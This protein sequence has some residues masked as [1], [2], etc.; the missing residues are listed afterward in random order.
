MGPIKVSVLTSVLNQ[1]EWLKE[2]IASVIASTFKDWEQ[3][4][5]DDG[6]TEDIKGIVESFNDPRVRYFRFP[7]N[8]GI[9]HGSNF[10]LSICAGEY[11]CLLAADEVVW[12]EKMQLQYDYLEANSKVDCVWGLPTR[13]GADHRVFQSEFGR[14]PDWEQNYYRA[15]NRSRYSWMRT[16]LNVEGV[17]I[18]GCSLDRKST[19]L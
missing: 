7:E 17:P 12:P 1:G 18:G 5:V 13:G 14:R 10:A 2:S 8:R 15:H 9:P 3:I 6:S 4:V 19:R 11:V 16:L